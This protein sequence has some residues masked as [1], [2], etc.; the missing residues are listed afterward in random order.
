MNHEKNNAAVNGE[1]LL[2][3]FEETMQSLNENQ[4][5]NDCLEVPVAVSA[6]PLLHNTSNDAPLSKIIEIK[7]TDILEKVALM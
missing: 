4:N 1:E 7:E 3:W 2:V 6:Q 5:A